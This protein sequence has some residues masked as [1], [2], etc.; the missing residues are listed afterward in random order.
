MRGL[1][2]LMDFFFTA[3]LLLLYYDYDYYDYDHDYDYTTTTATML[4]WRGIKRRRGCSFCLYFV[5][6]VVVVVVFFGVFWK[7]I[8]FQDKIK[9]EYVGEGKCSVPGPLVTWMTK[10]ILRLD[11]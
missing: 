9:A 4:F 8:P 3:S 5:V 11:L 7:P 1:V 2:F 6:V 10:F